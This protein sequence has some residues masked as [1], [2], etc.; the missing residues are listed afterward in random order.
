MLLF[1][2]KLFYSTLH[3]LWL[4]NNA[5]QFYIK[6]NFGNLFAPLGR[7]NNLKCNISLTR[8]KYHKAC[9]IIIPALVQHQPNQGMMVIARAFIAH[10]AS[11]KRDAL[12][13]EEGPSFALRSSLAQL[14]GWL[15]ASTNFSKT[16]R[17]KVP[18]VPLLN[19]I[20]FR[21]LSLPSTENLPGRL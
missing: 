18:F 12:V 9:F 14:V 4:S 5:S 17:A 16:A 6:T 7:G 21:P 10:N 2:L 1:Q 8:K 19:G 15:G 20:I 11:I 3:Y 13:E